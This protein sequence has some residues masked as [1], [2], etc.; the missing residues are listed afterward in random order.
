MSTLYVF[1]LDIWAVTDWK[2]KKERK[3]KVKKNCDESHFHPRYLIACVG[4]RHLFCDKWR[5]TQ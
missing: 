2:T 1:R 5:I 4:N 3:K